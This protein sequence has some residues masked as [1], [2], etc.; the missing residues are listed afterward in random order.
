[1]EQTYCQRC[2]K[3]L[4]LHMVTHYFRVFAPMMQCDIAICNQCWIGFVNYVNGTDLVDVVGKQ[5][6]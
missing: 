4:E 5:H 6:D 2:K 3:E 1:M